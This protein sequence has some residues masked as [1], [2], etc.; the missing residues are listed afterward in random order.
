MNRLRLTAPP[1]GCPKCL[2]RYN[3]PR[4]SRI[5][6]ATET[7][8]GDYECFVCGHVWWTAWAYSAAPEWVA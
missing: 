5:E 1:D 7:L 4:W 6:E 8:I 3:D 2:R